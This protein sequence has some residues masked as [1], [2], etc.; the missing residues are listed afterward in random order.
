MS[1]FGDLDV[2]EL[3]LGEVP[4]RVGGGWRR[5]VAGRGGGAG[6]WKILGAGEGH[7]WVHEA[8]EGVSGVPLHLSHGHRHTVNTANMPT[9]TILTRH[10]LVEPQKRRLKELFRPKI[11]V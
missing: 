9:Q 6:H 4:H 2:G 10:F 8:E 3:G 1:G 11:C 5:S 7:R